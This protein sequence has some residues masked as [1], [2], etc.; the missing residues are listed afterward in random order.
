MRARP[1]R[2]KLCA[3]VSV[4][5]EVVVPVPAAEVFDY[6]ADASNE[7]AWNP[8]VVRIARVS[9]GPIGRGTIFEGTYRRGGRM[10]F[11]ITTYEPPSRLVF[12]GGGRRSR[13]AATVRL[14]PNDA[15]TAVAMRADVQPRGPLRLL[16]PALRPLMERQYGDVVHR[17]GE[18]MRPS[19]NKAVYRRWFEEVVSG[20]DLALADEL[21]APGYRLHFPGMPGPLDGEGHKA[22]VEQFRA[23]FPD[24]EETVEDVVAEG[25]RVVI[26]VTGRGTHEG[27]FQGL[28]PTGRRVSATGIGIGRMASGRIAEAWAAYDALGLLAQLGSEAAA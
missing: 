27:E 5:R 12:E 14:T 20:G 6:M 18:A 9:N 13:L 1:G 26:R 28:A 7:Q 19:G 15:G 11:Q 21:L 16:S 25:D 2:G 3:M 22:L 17:L 10:R 8:N 23:A 24:W 4:Q